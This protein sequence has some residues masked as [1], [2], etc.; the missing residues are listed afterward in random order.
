M[1]PGPEE[2]E[3]RGEPPARMGGARSRQE[4]LHPNPEP[5]GGDEP[6]KVKQH[7]E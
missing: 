2:Q 1:R 6:E 3:L 7:D 5:H 4:P